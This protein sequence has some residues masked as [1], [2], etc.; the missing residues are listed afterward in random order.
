V[1]RTSSARL[2]EFRMLAA[3]MQEAAK[4]YLAKLRNR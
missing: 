3:A 1:W 2:R 4:T